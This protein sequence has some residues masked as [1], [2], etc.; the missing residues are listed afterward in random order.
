[1]IIIHLES[2]SIIDIDFTK[3][4]DIENV[5]HQLII[6]FSF[7][8]DDAVVIQVDCHHIWAIAKNV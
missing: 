2:T 3:S 6:V 7:L 5:H 8:S 4:E 1:M